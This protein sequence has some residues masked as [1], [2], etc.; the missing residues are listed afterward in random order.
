MRN[1]KLAVN[2]TMKSIKEDITNDLDT[3]MTVDQVEMFISDISGYTIDASGMGAYA[4]DRLIYDFD[5]VTLEHGM[6][7][8]GGFQSAIEYL[9]KEE[10]QLEMMKNFDD[11]CIRW[12]RSG[13]DQLSF[14]DIR[15]EI[16]KLKTF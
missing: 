9:I 12:N 7:A 10:I 3:V 13:D 14:S 1:L 5:H 6:M 8:M 16:L 11:L 2:A 4:L 15:S